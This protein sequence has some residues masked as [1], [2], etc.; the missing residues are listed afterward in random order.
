[1]VVLRAHPAK[2]PEAGGACRFTTKN[3]L[4]WHDGQHIMPLLACPKIP[5]TF[6]GKA[7]HHVENAMAA[8][9]ACLSQG[10]PDPPGEKRT[11]D[12]SAGS[13]P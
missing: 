9:A 8:A 5:V 3:T 10:S 1:L 4:Y 13:S 12:I 2:T 11:F 6:Q 7:V